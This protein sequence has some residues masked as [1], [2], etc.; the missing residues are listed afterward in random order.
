MS[1]VL[2]KIFNG[3]LQLVISETLCCVPTNG[4]QIHI[5]ITTE[6]NAI[7]KFIF[8][9]DPISSI[10]NVEVSQKDDNVIFV[11]TNF[12]NS[13]GASLST[14]F[15]FKVGKDIFFLQFY[16]V[17]TGENILCFTFSI[18]KEENG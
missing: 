12:L 9:S 5:P 8:N 1:K 13:L 6:K 3:N 18:F 11:L 2:P 16:G 4:I 7:F 10:R 17:S 14:P 15:K